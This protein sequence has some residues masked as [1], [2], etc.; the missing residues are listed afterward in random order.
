MMPYP[1]LA[2]E[3][4][5]AEEDQ[6]LTCFITPW[7]RY[8]FKRAPIGL[9]SSGDEYN[10]RGDQALGDILQTIKIVE[11]ALVYDKSY[12][13][14]LTHVIK[15]V[16]RCKDFGIT[17]NEEKIQFA[18]R[19]AEFCGYTMSNEG[20]T[21][22]SRKIKAIADFP[23]PQCITDLRSFLGLT[24]QLGQFSSDI[25]AAAQPV[26]DLLRPGNTWHWTSQHDE[27]FAKVKETLISPPI[28]AHYDPALPTMLQTDAS[29]LHGFG[30]VLL[31]RHNEV[32]RLVQCG[33]RFVTNT[34]SRYAMIELELGAVV[35]GM[36]KCH[37]YLVGLPH[38][39]LVIDHKPLVPLL[40]SK[41]LYEIDNPRLQMMM[42]KLTSFT[43]TASWQKGSLHY[44]Y[45][46]LSRSPIQDPCEEA[47]VDESDLLHVAVEAALCAVDDNGCILAPLRDMTLEK[48]RE[49]GNRDTEY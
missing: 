5:I 7:G 30:F 36:R 32:W 18:K 31:Q 35:W 21:V 42:E 29:R 6:D 48:V 9:V 43:F 28:L 15:V 10:R 46:A 34:E 25:S 26:R 27:A 22:D 47:V 41:L 19:K 37:V 49:R 3:L 38:F 17:L 2:Q 39:D 11:D 13:E 20:Y 33:S 4:K 45:D 12:K 1:P 16:Q 8:K 44:V 14:H 40:N 24:N 23:S